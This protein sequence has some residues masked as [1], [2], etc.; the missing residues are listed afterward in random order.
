MQ[1]GKGRMLRFLVSKPVVETGEAANVG[2]LTELT[3][4]IRTNIDAALAHFFAG[5][6]LT[7][8]GRTALLQDGM[9][10]RIADNMER[11]RDAAV[12]KEQ[13]YPAVV[14]LTMLEAMQE[15]GLDASNKTHVLYAL[16]RVKDYFPRVDFQRIVETVVTQ[17]IQERLARQAKSPTP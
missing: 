9:T 3:Q 2:S 10:A 12:V 17:A 16:S 15:A 14:V 8:E 5:S 1:E 7:G 11:Y 13:G 4:E 6:S